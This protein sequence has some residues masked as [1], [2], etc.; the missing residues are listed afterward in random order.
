MS[1]LSGSDFALLALFGVQRQDTLLAA[2]CHALLGQ[3]LHVNSHLLEGPA[4]NV[5]L[6]YAARK[7]APRCLLF[8][9]SRAGAPI[10]SLLLEGHTIN[11]VS[12]VSPRT[13]FTD[14]M[15]ALTVSAMFLLRLF[16]AQSSVRPNRRVKFCSLR[17]VLTCLL[18]ITSAFFLR[19][20]ISARLILWFG[21]RTLQSHGLVSEGSLSGMW[22]AGWWHER[23]PATQQSGVQT[24]TAPHQQAMSTRVGTEW[25]AHVL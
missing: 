22:S 23:W 14:V 15:K 24:A 16:F 17:Q 10:V 4:I 21:E 12:V 18:H 1:F 5:T 11:T 13:S 8:H 3:E 25:L 2:F 6:R 7:H 9:P 20:G 19:C